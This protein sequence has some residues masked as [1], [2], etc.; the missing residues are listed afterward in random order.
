M[1]TEMEPSV[2]LN[3]KPTFLPEHNRLKKF[4]IPKRTSDKDILTDCSTNQRD[5]HEVKER[6]NQG[7][8]DKDCDLGSLWHFDKIEIVHNK[9]LEEEF[10]AKRTKMREQGRMD[11]ELSSF[12]V[13]SKEEVLKIC[14]SGLRTNNSINKE[15]GI[16]KELGNP[17]LGVYLFR[18][19]DI[20]LNYAVKHSAPVESIIIFRVLL[21]KVKKTLPLKGKKKVALDP[22]PNYDCHVSRIHPSLKDSIEDQAIGSLVYFYEYSELSKPV[23]RPRQCLPHAVVKVQCINQRADHPV[24]SLK[25]RPKRFSKGRGPA[26][27]LENCTIVT[28]IGDSKLIYEHFHKPQ[29][30]VT[31]NNICVEVPSLSETALNWNIPG[32]ET[33]GSKIQHQLPGRWDSAQIDTAVWDFNCVPGVDCNRDARSDHVGNCSK[34]PKDASVIFGE[35]STTITSKSIKDPRLRKGKNPGEQNGEQL[36]H[37]NL[38][39]EKELK[40]QTEIKMS[41]TLNLPWP[42]PKEPLL[43]NDPKK[44]QEMAHS[45]KSVMNEIPEKTNTQIVSSSEENTSKKLEGCID[46]VK[47]RMDT[48]LLTEDTALTLLTSNQGPLAGMKD[49]EIK[50]SQFE[51]TSHSTNEN[52]GSSNDSLSQNTMPEILEQELAVKSVDINTPDLEVNSEPEILSEGYKKCVSIPQNLHNL[53]EVSSDLEYQYLQDRMDWEI[54]LAKRSPNTEISKST[55]LKELKECSCEEKTD[56][57]EKATKMCNIYVRP[58]LQITVTDTLYPHHSSLS[59]RTGMV[60]F[61]TK[62]SGQKN[63]IKWHQEGK[64]EKD[65]PGQKNLRIYRQKKLPSI[66]RLPRMTHPLTKRQFETFEQSEKHIQNV[67]HTLNTEASSCKNKPLSQKIHG[68]MFHLK[69]AQKSV[70]KYLKILANIAKKKRNDSKGQKIVLSNLLKSSDCASSNVVSVQTKAACFTERKNPQISMLSSPIEMRKAGEKTSSKLE[71]HIESKED[72]TSSFLNAYE[73]PS[74][75]LDLD[76]SV[77]ST[78]VSG[79]PCSSNNRVTE[80]ELSDIVELSESQVTS[81]QEAFTNVVSENNIQEHI[82]PFMGSTKQE[83][84]SEANKNIANH[85][86]V[87]TGTE[88]LNICHADLEAAADAFVSNVKMGTVTLDKSV[89]ESSGKLEP[90][91][92][93]EISK[94]PLIF[95][96]NETEAGNRTPSLQNDL[97]MSVDRTQACDLSPA[98]VPVLKSRPD[99]REQA[100]LT[101]QIHG[102]GCKTKTNNF[103]ERNL[104]KICSEKLLEGQELYENKRCKS[105]AKPVMQSENNIERLNG[106]LIQ[107]SQVTCR[108]ESTNKETSR[109]SHEKCHSMSS[110]RG[111]SRQEGITVTTI[112]PCAHDNVLTRDRGLSSDC[113]NN[114]NTITSFAAQISEILQKADETSCLNLLQEQI[115]VCKNIL[116]LFI[117]ALEEKQ[118]C[119]FEQVLVSMENAEKS[120]RAKL[121]PCA[122]ESLVELQIIMETVEFLEN[123]RRYLQGKHT[124]RS[125]LWFDDS[126]CFELF[127]G[128]SG[129]QQQSNFYPAFQRSLKYSA[130]NELQ[131]HHKKLVDKFEITR[132]ENKSYYCLLKLRREIKECEAAVQS[133]SLLSEFFLSEPYICGANYGDTVEDLENARKTTVDLI[134]TC[135]SLSSVLLG[136]EKMEHLGIIMDIISTKIEFIRTCEEGNIKSSFIGLEHIFFNAAVSCILRERPIFVNGDFKSREGEMLKIYEAALPKLYE[137]YENKLERNFHCVSEEHIQSKSVEKLCSYKKVDGGANYDIGNQLISYPEIC[138][139]EILDEA[140]YLN[141]EK[142]RQHQCRCIEQLEVLK[143]YFQIIQEEDVDRVLITKENVL[144][145]MESSGLRAIRLKPEAVEVYTDL[146]M[147]HETLC[148]LQNSIAR[149]EDEPRFRSLLWCDLSLVNELFLCQQKMASFSYRKDNLL[150]NIESAISDLQDE[151]N[152]VYDYA[153]SLNCSYARHLLM[154]ELEEL[155]E[156]RKYLQTSVS[157]ICMCVDLVPYTVALNYGSTISE[158]EYNYEQF[159]SLLEKL[160]L[161]DRKDL[162][163]MAHVMKILKTIEHMKYICTKQQKPPLHLVICQMLKNW[164]K[165]RRLK[166]QEDIRR[167]TDANGSNSMKHKRPAAITSEDNPCDCEEKNDSSDSKKQKVVASLATTK[168]KQEKEICKNM[169]KGGRLKSLEGEELQVLLGFQPVRFLLKLGGFSLFKCQKHFFLCTNCAFHVCVFYSDFLLCCIHQMLMF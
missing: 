27:L 2:T 132:L 96:G 118:D 49:A 148:F 35:L 135:R 34:N 48:D 168:K 62:F 102:S 105:L 144:N 44:L 86:N 87:V 160:L 66:H 23:D 33:H 166:K 164:R 128:Q 112:S 51:N 151:L 29:N 26:L 74:G 101:P 57:G 134:N 54:L 10:V 130:L 138:I 68:V 153:E 8:F 116:P 79:M 163:K 103:S 147:V 140:Q 56:V 122:I 45:G 114:C 25:S 15:L 104:E 73:G 108:K 39:C 97:S 67:L 1:K 133:N 150:E 55:S 53:T 155:L 71:S 146:A 85:L 42:D 46:D 117:R 28:R 136:T 65:T 99:S 64:K 7:C 154:R 80:H 94:S 111:D 83:L 131:S 47:N 139:G 58:D 109:T 41:A 127:G 152:V 4:T 88:E 149:K 69:K 75:A 40:Y 43:L 24:I 38:Q 5:Y 91:K 162:G 13:V 82:S 37:G 36:S 76:R 16:S 119:S 143:K 20:A 72:M 159:Y 169:R 158:L 12:L 145:F 31:N 93:H 115:I 32:A 126:Q 6:L 78:S 9:D 167:H 3:A 90:S 107:T 22:T 110:L 89:E 59:M 142:L 106:H 77:T 120:M 30:C 60:K 141:I 18:H 70:Q 14:Q 156:T 165:S 129:Y 113:S 17:Q 161:A 124:F 121:K 137:I 50:H 95:S 92:P 81:E 125:L 123:K 98:L 11:K 21:G 19:V 52:V 61:L 63:G 100:L 84:S 157:S